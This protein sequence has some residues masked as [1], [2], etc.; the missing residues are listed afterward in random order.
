MAVATGR[1]RRDRP[2]TGDAA[3]HLQRGRPGEPEPGR[4]HVRNTEVVSDSTN[5][6]A[7]EAAARRRGQA[8]NDRID[9]AACH[10]QLRAQVF[11]PGQLPTSGCSPWSPAPATAGRA[12]PK[13]AC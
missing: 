2:I 3:G 6:L 8:R 7:V 5:V 4:R 11:G 1:V 13:P 10:R 9:L 12:A